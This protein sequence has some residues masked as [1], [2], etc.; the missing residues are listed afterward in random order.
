[1]TLPESVLKV[2]DAQAREFATAPLGFSGRD[3]F[4]EKEYSDFKSGALWAYE[5]GRKDALAEVL[6]EYKKVEAFIAEVSD[7]VLEADYID[8]SFYNWFIERFNETEIK[9]GKSKDQAVAIALSVAK[10]AKKKAKKK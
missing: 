10:E 2:I 3:S 4:D 5:Q 6:P 7:K 9:H 1:M 8:L